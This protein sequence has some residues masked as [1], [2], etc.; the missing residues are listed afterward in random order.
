M[1]AQPAVSLNSTV[2]QRDDLL[3]QNLD[4]DIVMANIDA[5]KYYGVKLTARRIWE[6]IKVSSKVSTVC[7]RL[8]VEFDV[9]R[10]V[11][12]RDVLAF[13]NELQQEG[14]IQVAD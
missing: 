14:L 6:I 4:E 11:C 9:E 13:L 7:E 5:G 10:A 3:A 2:K 12:E 1:T 8:L